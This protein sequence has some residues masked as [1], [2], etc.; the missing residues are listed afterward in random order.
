MI[1]IELLAH[2]NQFITFLEPF[3]DISLNYFDECLGCQ[4]KIWSDKNWTL[5]SK[6]SILGVL[7]H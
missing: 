2:F 1:V 4:Q 5:P 3:L 7:K 6:A